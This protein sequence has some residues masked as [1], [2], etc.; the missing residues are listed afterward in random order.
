[1]T[2]GKIRQNHHSSQWLLLPTLVRALS[3]R[4]ECAIVCQPWI[5]SYISSNYFRHDIQG[6]SLLS[7]RSLLNKLKPVSEVQLT[8]CR[9][10]WTNFIHS[11]L[12]ALKVDM[13]DYPGTLR[14]T[15]SR[16]N[17]EYMSCMYLVCILY[18]LLYNIIMVL[19]YYFKKTA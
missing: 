13:S 4:D 12:V 2:M 3:P 1:M 15:L 11:I 19:I 16:Q 10:N 14:N 6:N 8:I 17:V 9:Q 18:N 7:L 5:S